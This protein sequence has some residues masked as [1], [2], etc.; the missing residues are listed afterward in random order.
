MMRFIR[1]LNLAPLLGHPVSDDDLGCRP[2][3]LTLKTADC[4]VH[5]GVFYKYI[6]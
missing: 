6:H 3:L 1:K 5:D 4:V 2:K